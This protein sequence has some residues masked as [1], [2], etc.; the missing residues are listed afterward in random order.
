LILDTISKRS[1]VDAKRAATLTERLHQ[2]LPISTNS[3]ATTAP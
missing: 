2:V 1:R 3:V